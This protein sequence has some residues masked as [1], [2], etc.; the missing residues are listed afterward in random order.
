[1]SDLVEFS[2]TDFPVKANS[3]A[4]R[5]ILIS[6][7]IIPLTILNKDRFV[8]YQALLDTGADYNVFHAD[9]ADYLGITL[10]KGKSMRVTGI[11]GDSIKGYIHV[12]EI[13]VGKK[14]VKTSILFSRQIPDNATAVLGNQGFFDHFCVTFNYKDKAITIK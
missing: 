12:V 14:L 7:P 6:R 8:Q 5:T 1:M 2:Y 13:K 3:S 4:K 9:I 11:G 10:T